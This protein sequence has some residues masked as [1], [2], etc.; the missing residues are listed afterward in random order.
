M[1]VLLLVTSLLPSLT[2]QVVT[3]DV[4]ARR[5]R[6]DQATPHSFVSNIVHYV[7]RMFTPPRC[8]G[9]DLD[10]IVVNLNQSLSDRIFEEYEKHTMPPTTIQR[11]FVSFDGTI[12]GAP[13]VPDHTCVV[14]DDSEFFI[15][16]QVSV[17]L[18]FY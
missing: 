13:S 12:S 11:R 8:P 7:L 18:S 10:F 17:I 16:L 1:S 9:G 3:V 4:S 15:H 6:P 5:L 2:P 14:S